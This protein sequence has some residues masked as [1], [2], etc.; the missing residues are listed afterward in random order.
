[1]M[2]EKL[3]LYLVEIGAALLALGAAFFAIR[4]SGEKAEQAKQTEKALEQAKDASEIDAKVRALS[5]ADLAAKLREH[6]RS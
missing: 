4:R 3:K 1:M 5:D 6:E 2:L